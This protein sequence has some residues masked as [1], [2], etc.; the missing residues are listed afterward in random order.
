[1]QD[2][3]GQSRS[4]CAR[5]GAFH[6]SSNSCVGI[7]RS[8]PLWPRSSSSR[9]AQESSF[10]YHLRFSILKSNSPSGTQ[11]D[12]SMNMPAIITDMHA[13]PPGGGQSNA[14]LRFTVARAWSISS[15][16][17]TQMADGNSPNMVS[18]II[19]IPRSQLPPCFRPSPLRVTFVGTDIRISIYTPCF[20]RLC[21]NWAPAEV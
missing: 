9:Q 14:P 20:L 8:N 21:W 10:R 2:K 7:D 5:F 13:G 11:T 3:R 4:S 1:M 15:F 16:D 18:F 12:I 19:H 6:P 17:T